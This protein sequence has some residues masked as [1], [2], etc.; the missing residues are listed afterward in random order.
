MAACY[1]DG[2]TAGISDTGF[3]FNYEVT[4]TQAALMMMKA[5][6]YFQY[7]KDFGGDWQVA[8]VKQLI[9]MGILAVVMVIALILPMVSTFWMR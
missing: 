4:T 9:V 3:G 8:T 7:A 2:N 5:L 1:A 6:G